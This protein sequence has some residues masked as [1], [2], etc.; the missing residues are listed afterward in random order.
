MSIK[1]NK[2][3]TAIQIRKGHNTKITFVYEDEYD[4]CFPDTVWSSVKDFLGIFAK[5]IRFDLPFLMF[6]ERPVKL[7]GDG[8]TSV[9]DE[10]PDEE[11]AGFQWQ[12][13][14]ALNRKRDLRSE[15]LNRCH[16]DPVYRRLQALKFFQ[17]K[18]PLRKGVVYP[19]RK[20][21]IKGSYDL[22]DFNDVSYLKYLPAGMYPKPVLTREER[23]AKIPAEV[24]IKWY[25][26]NP[27]CV[28]GTRKTPC[29]ETGTFWTQREWNKITTFED[30]CIEI[31]DPRTHNVRV[32]R[33]SISSHDTWSWH[34]KEQCGLPM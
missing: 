6:I 8:W 30:K 16:I 4:W 34:L 26:E 12:Y 18:P 15:I 1:S 28:R 20:G 19:E 10:E 9:Q 29:P 3:E 24:W 32:P 25:E 27:E 33:T 7:S 22:K 21:P 14:V 31:Y 11:M 2:T 5:V 17:E 23:K 13:N